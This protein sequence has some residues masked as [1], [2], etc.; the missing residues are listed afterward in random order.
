V[1]VGTS[2]VTV[3][4]IGVFTDMASA[5]TMKYLIFD[6]TGGDMLVFESAAEPFAD[7]GAVAT[8]KLSNRMSFTLLAGRNY[9]IAG[10]SDVSGDFKLDTGANSAGGLTSLVD[11][12]NLMNFAVPVVN[13]AHSSADC[14]I[15]LFALP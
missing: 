4:R 8:W 13:T 6:H 12:P 7:D 2:D 15:Q 14:G 9:C 3:N 1:A 10:S 11:N 5:G